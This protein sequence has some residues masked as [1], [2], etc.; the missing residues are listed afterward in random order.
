MRLPS[1]GALAN[2]SYS[3][4][5]SIARASSSPRIRI[6]EQQS[7]KTK[8]RR[9]PAAGAPGSS[10][11]APFRGSETDTS[12]PSLN[13]SRLS[14]PPPAQ[15]GCNVIVP[16]AVRDLQINPGEFHLSGQNR[17]ILTQR[18]LCVRKRHPAIILV[19]SRSSDYQAPFFFYRLVEWMAF[20]RRSPATSRCARTTLNRDQ[21]AEAQPRRYPIAGLGAFAVGAN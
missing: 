6:C 21:S 12:Q 3:A 1:Q 9:Q 15:Y 13:S 8:W 11:S 10:A 7:A 5:S 4:S 20:F 2:R 18:P 17:N 16:A 19:C 14:R